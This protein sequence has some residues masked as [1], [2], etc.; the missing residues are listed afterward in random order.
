MSIMNELTV[1][2]NAGAVTIA[3]RTAVEPDLP[4]WLDDALDYDLETDGWR[5]NFLARH[6]K[7]FNP[8]RFTMEQIEAA[9]PLRERYAALLAPPPLERMMQWL[10]AINV[11]VAN[12]KDEAELKVFATALLAME[13]PLGFFTAKTATQIAKTSKFFP[14]G[15]EINDLAEPMIRRWRIIYNRLQEI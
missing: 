4:R 9:I 11:L 8:N 14:T 13:I 2:P 1:T 6:N 15:K 5:R 12:P 3:D 7:R 10:T